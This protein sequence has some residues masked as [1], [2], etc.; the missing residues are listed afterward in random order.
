MTTQPEK[1]SIPKP[2][3]FRMPLLLLCIG[4]I[5]LLLGVSFWK[6]QTKPTSSYLSA[7]LPTTTAPFAPGTSLPTGT[8]NPSMSNNIPATNGG[9][10]PLLFGTNLSLYDSNDQVLQSASTRSQLE[11]MHFRII[12]MPVRA[13]LSNT[14]EIQAAQAI[15]SM[16]AYAL[17]V[18]RGEVDNNVLADDTRII[19]DMNAIYGHIVVFYEY[20][21]EED[22][23]GVD[24][25]RYTASWNAI[26]P[27]LKRIAFNGQFIGPVNYQYDQTYLTTFLQHANPR[28]DEISWHEYTCDDASSDANCLAQIDSWTEHITNARATMQSTLSTVLPI[29]ITEWNYAPNAHSNDG[30]IDDSHFMS[31]W[32]TKAVQ[33]LATNRI[34]ASMQYTCTNS[35]YALVNSD[36]TP[37]IQGTT[38]RDLYAR[39]I[40][41]KQQ[42]TPVAALGG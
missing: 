10:S 38:I 16:G 6:L 4:M 25:N 32:T 8:T 17:V 7:A 39:M 13:S 35:V 40:V 33:T 1:D 14:T 28:P 22:L 5:A 11:Q 23:L 29:M 21:N 34:F 2:G 9:V 41:K 3:C 20:G 15:R 12:R 18:L 26:V 27:Q 36:G 30:K 31:M 37:S 24:V 19:Q 42:P